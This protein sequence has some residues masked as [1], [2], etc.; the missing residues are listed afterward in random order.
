M[1]MV[2]A[3]A[4]ILTLLACSAL[5]GPDVI[6][7][8]RAKELRDQ[9]NVR[10]G[11]A[12]PSQPAQAAKPATATTAAAPGTTLTPQQANLVRLQTDLASFKADSP[13]TAAQQQR[14]AND[15]SAVAQGPNKPS[16]LAIS[17][18]A[19][20]LAAAL[21]QKPLGAPERS[22]LLQNL[23]AALN[24]ASLPQSQ[25]QA[26]AADIQAIF[27]ANG[28]NRDRAVAVG[29]DVKAVGVEVQKTAAAK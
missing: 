29:N 9:N 4:G 23:N 3:Q 22:R 26:I 1:K 5:A 24:G 11:V 25:M 14:L 18:L 12:P 19:N 20:S 28:G 2:F 7:R 13:V 17:K 10:Q 27:Q 8:E 21:A 6:I 15:L 16:T